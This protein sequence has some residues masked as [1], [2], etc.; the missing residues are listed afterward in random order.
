MTPK[1]KL[2][3]KEALEAYKTWRETRSTI[4]HWEWQ[5]KRSALEEMLAE[6]E[7]C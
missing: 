6:E 5:E 7:K 2:A 4:T 1:E 3:V